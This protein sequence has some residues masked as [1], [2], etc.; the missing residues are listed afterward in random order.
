LVFVT[1]TTWCL[2]SPQLSV[3]HHHNLVFIIT[4]THVNI[5]S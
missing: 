2:S 3:Y 1:T 5:F 4:T